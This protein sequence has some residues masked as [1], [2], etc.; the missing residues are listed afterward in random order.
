MIYSDLKAGKSAAFRVKPHP[1]F[2][3][4]PATINNDP[5]IYPNI[6]AEER[7]DAKTT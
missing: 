7:R 5:D 1:D 2:R 4:V 3:E 6:G